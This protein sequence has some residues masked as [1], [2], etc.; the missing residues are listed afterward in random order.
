[1]TFD[2]LF[3]LNLIEWDGDV[4]LPLV[5]IIDTEESDA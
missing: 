2:Q 5:E 1:M 4:P 3:D